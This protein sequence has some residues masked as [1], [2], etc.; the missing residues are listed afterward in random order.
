MRFEKCLIL[1]L[2]LAVVI[3][4]CSS[5]KKQNVTNSG[6]PNIVIIYLDD[7]GYG[8]VSAYGATEIQTPNIDRLANNGVMFTDGHASSA[9]CTPSRYALLTG[10]YP[11]RNKDAKILPGTAPLIIDTAQVTIP[12]MLKKQGYH[13]GIVGKWHLGLGRGQVNW[14]EH[15]SPGPTK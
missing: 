12:K 10:V 4:S 1:M 14:N 11:W 5:Y 6:K 9:T 15:V 8:D 3:T 7:L 2:M 13:T